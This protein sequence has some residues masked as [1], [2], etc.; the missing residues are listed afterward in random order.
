MKTSKS[1][2]GVSL[3]G[4]IFW[5]VVVSMLALLG[6]KVVPT[7]IEYYMLKKDIKATVANLPPGATV[8][9]VRK[10][11]AKFVEIDRLEMKPEEL[12]ISKENNQVVIAFDYE[13]KI[14]LFSNIS[15]LINYSGSSSG[16]SS[17]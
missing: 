6:M 11:Y 12:E 5:G 1:Q 15:L 3:S 4:L 10:A 8:A 13:K 9:D 17:E 14:P 16:G 7:V 2:R